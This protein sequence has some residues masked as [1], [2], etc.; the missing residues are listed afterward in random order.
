MAGLTAVELPQIVPGWNA[1]NGAQP[2]PMLGAGQAVPAGAVVVG[3]VAGSPGAGGYGGGA[4]DG[5]DP[6][7][8]ARPPATAAIESDIPWLADEGKDAVVAPPASVLA[9]KVLSMEKQPPGI[10]RVKDGADLYSALNELGLMYSMDA[11]SSCMGRVV[12]QG[13]VGVVERQGHVKFTKPGQWT[14][15]DYYTSWSDPPMQPISSQVIKVKGLTI[16]TLNQRECCVAQDQDG[17]SNLLSS[18]RF[19]IIAPAILCESPD[20]RDSQAVISLVNLPKQLQVQRFNFFNVPQGEVAGVTLPSGQVRILLPGVHIVEDCKF[21]RFLPTVPIQSKL[22]K[23]VVT[24]DLVTVSLEVDI[25]TQLVDCARFLKMS[26]GAV[27]TDQQGR[28]QLGVG[29]KDLYDAIEESAQS[30]FVDTFGKTQYYNFRTRQGEVE[31]KFEETALQ[32]LD[33]EARKYGGRILKVNILKQRADAVEAVYAS[34]NSKQIE[35]EQKKQSQQR[36]YDI[37]DNDQK[38]K[39]QMAEREEKGLQQK[40][41]LVQ[42]RETQQRQH[43]LRL[44][45]ADSKAAQEKMDFESKASSERQKYQAEAEAAAAKVR[46]K[47]QAEQQADQILVVAQAQAKAEELRGHAAAMAE[48]LKT[49]ARVEGMQQLAAVLKENPAMLELEKQRIHDE[50]QVAKLKALVEA[51]AHVVPVELMRL[52]DVADERVLKRMENQAV[53]HVAGAKSAHGGA[54]GSK[55]SSAAGYF[56]NDNKQN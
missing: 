37:D 11:G 33:R 4:G 3:V 50:L 10:V 56:G 16:V 48:Q 31:S 19:I 54:A 25:A 28:Q 20:R 49:K 52:M 13:Q 30:H 42:E 44:Q 27:H 5:K 6:H 40:Q 55:G 45:M 1:K 36:Q 21:E 47:G 15:W 14:L 53:L 35:L 26:A 41:Q 7:S 9:G 32:V 46:A 12:D 22:K 17:R 23:E 8:H 18:G 24:S 43:N 2:I 39:Q 34:H 29:C 51:G 38:H